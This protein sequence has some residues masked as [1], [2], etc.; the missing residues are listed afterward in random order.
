MI[1]FRFDNAVRI[2]VNRSSAVLAE[3]ADVD[4]RLLFNASKAL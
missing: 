1:T 3:L 4:H 2:T